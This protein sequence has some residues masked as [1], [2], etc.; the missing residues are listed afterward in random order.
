MPTDA[1]ILPPPS[2]EHRRIAAGQFDRANQV[3]AA[4]LYDYGIQ[5]L[6]ACCQLD[7]ANLIY[8]QRLRQTQKAK[9]QNNLRG[10]RL[11]FLTTLPA[12]ARLKA[13]LQAHDYLRALAVGEEILVQNP[14]DTGVQ[15]NMAEAARRLDLLDLAAWILEQARQ[16]DPQ[17]RL[18]NRTLAGLYEARGHFQQAQ[19]LWAL[20]AQADPR[21]PEARHKV[22]VLAANADQARQSS[23]EVGEWG[24]GVGSSNPSVEGAAGQEPTAIQALEEQ[25]AQDPTN[26]PSYLQLAR[27]HRQAGRLDEAQSVLRR[28]LGPTG[29]RFELTT[30]LVELDI[31]PFRHNLAIV[32]EKLK[33]Q[34]ADAGLREIRERLLKEINTRELELYRRQADRF[35]RNQTFRFELGVR[36]LRAG[37][38]D[39][40]IEELEE[41]E[42]ESGHY[43][44]ARFY[45]GHCYNY[46]NN[47]PLA[48]RS[49]EEAL[50][51]V[52]PAE[53]AAR[54]ELLFQ[55]AQGAANAGDLAKA[56]D[57]GRGLAGVDA[58]Y[59]AIGQRVREWQDRLESPEQEE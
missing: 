30:E 31:E 4:G 15:L 50:L 26:A 22:A 57:I 6:L 1:S 7:P 16:R 38:M 13:A 53:E 5:L 11:A 29:N 47:W 27:L 34:P 39:E 3:I 54:K 43:W 48:E 21:D 36:L 2:P 8:R 33:A 56:I 20:V 51:H 23:M 59:R 37:Q 46:R 44:Q 55:L 14:W 12:K 41:V 40:G 52:P 58:E 32:E 9:Y 45:L 10:R 42:A 18:V 28:G 24:K 35:P 25:I 17:D 19:E 49:F